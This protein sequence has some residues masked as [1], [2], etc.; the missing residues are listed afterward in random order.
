M[1]PQPD[2]KA[3]MGDAHP[4]SIIVIPMPSDALNALLVQQSKQNAQ[5]SFIIMG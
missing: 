3:T 1:T 5:D 2:R 4:P